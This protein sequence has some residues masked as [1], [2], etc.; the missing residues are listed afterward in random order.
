MADA[1]G[2]VWPDA[3]IMFLRDGQE[4]VEYLQRDSSPVPSLL[5]MDVRMTRMGAFE[6]LAWLRNQPKLRHLAVVVFTSA[7]REEDAARAQHLE[8]KAYLAKPFDYAAWKKLIRSFEAYLVADA[9]GS[10]SSQ[11]ENPAPKHRV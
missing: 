4:V 8:V 7:L 3:R 10:S 9:A 6:V 2:S 5:V 11:A 1:F